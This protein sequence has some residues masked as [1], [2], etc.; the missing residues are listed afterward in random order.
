MSEIGEKNCRVAVVTSVE[1]HVAQLVYLQSRKTTTSSDPEVRDGFEDNLAQWV[2]RAAIDTDAEASFGIIDYLQSD[3]EQRVDLPE[4]GTR[5]VGG[6]YGVVSE[7]NLGDSWSSVRKGSLVHEHFMSEKTSPTST[8][9]WET[10]CVSSSTLDGQGIIRAISVAN[11]LRRRNLEK[12][13]AD[14]ERAEQALLEGYEVI[15]DPSADIQLFEGLHRATDERGRTYW[16]VPERVIVSN[17]HGILRLSVSLW[18]Q[19]DMDDGQ[20][21]WTGQ[22]GFLVGD[23]KTTATELW[24]PYCCPFEAVDERG[25]PLEK[26]KKRVRVEINVHPPFRSLSAAQGL[27]EQR[28][29]AEANGHQYVAQLDGDRAAGDQGLGGIT[30]TNFRNTASEQTYHELREFGSDIPAERGTLTGPIASDL[31]IPIEDV[32]ESLDFRI[33][34]PGLGNS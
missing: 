21:D 14:L 20:L 30:F 18:H 6:C 4:E 11:E 10:Y 5:V 3:L 26:N 13:I 22:V 25:V 24:V 32:D 23:D 19:P 33:R 29:I 1:D 9:F 16:K 34:F 17:R 28:L 31:L 8:R 2:S 12:V 15:E 27:E 7:R